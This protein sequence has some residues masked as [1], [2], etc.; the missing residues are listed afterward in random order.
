MNMMRDRVGFAAAGFL[1]MTLLVPDVAV[2]GEAAHTLAPLSPYR[3]TKQLIAGGGA[4]MTSV[5]YALIGS[6][7]QSVAG[8][9]S[10]SR[11]RLDQGFHQRV[12][13]T[14]PWSFTRSDGVSDEAPVDPDSLGGS[15]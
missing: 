13:L 8:P 14:V 7:G 12:T 5:R 15:E 2:A 4:R 1:L 11:Y 9:R 10:Q 6:I 3:L